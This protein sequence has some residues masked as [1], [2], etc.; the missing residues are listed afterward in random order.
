ME[1]I[2][3]QRIEKSR[4]IKAARKKELMEIVF[5]VIGYT[6]FTTIFTMLFLAYLGG[7]ID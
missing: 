5:G 2:I 4:Q 1:D 6:I 7:W 3:K